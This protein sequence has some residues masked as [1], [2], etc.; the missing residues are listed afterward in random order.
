MD[1]ISQCK[2]ACLTEEERI[3]AFAGAMRVVYVALPGWHF[4]GSSSQVSVHGLLVALEI[5]GFRE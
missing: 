5:P 3:S 4:F 2:Y 1:E